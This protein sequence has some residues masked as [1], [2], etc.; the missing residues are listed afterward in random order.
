MI[1]EMVRRRSGPT[2]FSDGQSDRNDYVSSFEEG[3]VAG[4]GNADALTNKEYRGGR[5]QRKARLLLS[6]LCAG[7]LFSGSFFFL[8]VVR[9]GP[10]TTTS[11][12][13]TSSRITTT[14]SSHVF[15]EE[16]DQTSG[17]TTEESECTVWIAPSS[18]KGVN[19]YGVFTTRDIQKG[20]PILGAPDGLGVIVSPARIK[21]H[22]SIPALTQ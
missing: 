19:G 7:V 13:T 16:Q 8:S 10:L 1:P 15:M 17:T 14:R 6:W 12:A 5:P 22:F 2:R 18:L 21:G 9:L 4:D 3:R 20:E 11:I